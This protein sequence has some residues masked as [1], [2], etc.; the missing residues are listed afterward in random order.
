MKMAEQN[1][2]EMMIDDIQDEDEE[3]NQVTDNSTN[4]QK[5]KWYLIDT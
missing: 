5:I 3:D 1:L 4:S 2:R